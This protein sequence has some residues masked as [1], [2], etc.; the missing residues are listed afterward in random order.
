[1]TAGAAR[2]TGPIS[3]L[4]SAADDS[5]ADDSSADDV[6]TPAVRPLPAGQ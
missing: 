4:R 5:S 1:M 6:A 2:P 3:A